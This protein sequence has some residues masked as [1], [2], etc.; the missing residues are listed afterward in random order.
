[1]ADTVNNFITRFNDTSQELG[2]HYEIVI[3]DGDWGMLDIEGEIRNVLEWTFDNGSVLNVQTLHS[4]NEV[5]Q[6]FFVDRDE[7]V[8]LMYETLVGYGISDDVNDIMN[9]EET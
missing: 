9:H 3:E 2:S 4:K 6:V 7:D 5:I 1:M 8:E